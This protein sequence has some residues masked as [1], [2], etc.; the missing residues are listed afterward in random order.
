[1]ESQKTSNWAKKESHELRTPMNAIIGFSRLA[2]GV[3]SHEDAFYYNKIYKAALRMQR[4]LDRM[5]DLDEVDYK[6]HSSKEK[7]TMIGRVL[8]VDDEVMN[9]QV[10]KLVLKKFGLKVDMA[11]NG[12]KAIKAVLTNDYDVILMDLQ[13][14]VADGF[15]TTR[16]I[17]N[18]GLTDIPIIALTADISKES[19]RRCSKVGMAGYLTK[20]IVPK[21]LYST[22]EQWLG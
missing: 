15:T 4:V 7:T 10:A 20:P 11:E 5:M 9:R 17:K 2:K 3:L 22:I 16:A 1:M 8:V 14:P 13:M 18:R 21:K 12:V 6:A 19:R